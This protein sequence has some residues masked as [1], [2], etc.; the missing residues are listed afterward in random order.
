MMV[1]Q[2][3]IKRTFSDSG[4]KHFPGGK[5]M[6]FL[7]VCLLPFRRRNQSHC[8]LDENMKFINCWAISPS[9]Q[10]LWQ[11]LAPM[12]SSLA[13]TKAFQRSTSTIY[14]SLRFTTTR[15]SLD[16]WMDELHY[17]MFLVVNFFIYFLWFSHFLLEK[18]LS[19]WLGNNERSKG[20]L[21]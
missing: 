8:A 12:S 13:P 1:N 15:G 2:F 18:F 14:Y 7:R 4:E 20:R 11:S 10:K 16:N 6:T 17:E 19:G 5:L 3:T 9:D 21:S